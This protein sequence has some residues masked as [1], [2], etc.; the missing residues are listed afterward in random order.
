MYDFA[1]HLA[2][3]VARLAQAFPAVPTV[4]E[5]PRLRQ[6][7]A[8]PAILVELADATPTDDA[9]T[10]QLCLSARFEARIVFDHVP[11]AGSNPALPALNLAAAVARE[12]FAAGRFGQPVGPAKGV[13]IEPDQFRPELSGY[14]VWLVEWTHEVRLGHSVWDGDGVMPTEIYLGIAPEIGPPHL[15]DYVKIGGSQ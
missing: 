3:V 13:R 9:G 5:Y 11:V 12:I 7:I 1:A 10:E 6:K 15:D 4:A 14:A 2:A 8:A